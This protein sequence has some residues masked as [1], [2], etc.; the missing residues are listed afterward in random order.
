MGLASLLVLGLAPQLIAALALNVRQSVS[1]D[2]STSANSGDTC[3]SFA[4][5][6]GLTESDF[7]ALN[8]G[9]SCPNL[10][11]EQSYC[12]IGTSPNTSSSSTKAQTTSS[13][14]TKASTTSSTAKVTTTTTSSSPYQPTQSGLAANCNNFHLV[15]SGDSCAAIETQYGISAADFSTWNPSID[16]TCD[17]LWLGY[18]VCVGVPGAKT[19]T[20]ATTTAAPTSTGPSPQ[21]P[22]ITGT[23]N[24][25]HQVASGD[26]C[27][28][29]EQA[30]GISSAQFLAWNPYVDA[31]CDN[32]W[33]GYYVCVGAKGATTT[34][35]PTTTTTATPTGPSPQMPSITSSCHKYYQVKS[36]DSCYTIEQTNSI[37][38]A[39]FLSWNKYVDAACDNLWLGYYVCV[40]V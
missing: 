38:L 35:K 31:A 22:S 14:S 36:G 23:C 19:T 2:F 32:L 1:C 16:S 3:A 24:A 4:A 33:L 15:A 13:S 17:N 26:S 10:V 6:W 37:T 28:T 39:Q 21:M 30:A 8:P 25:Y 40:G 20:K 7:E 18:Y 34:A 5:D 9:V 29:I 27:V 11:A 12:V